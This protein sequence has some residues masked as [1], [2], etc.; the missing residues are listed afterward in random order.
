MAE[1]K[2]KHPHPQP[3][4]VAPAAPV[5]E[6][7]HFVADAGAAF[8]RDCAGSPR[9]RELSEGQ[10]NFASFAATLAKPTEAE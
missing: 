6:A 4:V 5:V 2:E 8:A 3:A 1:K 10:A 9:G 7:P